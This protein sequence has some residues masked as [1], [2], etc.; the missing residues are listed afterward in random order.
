MN[1]NITKKTKQRLPLYLSYLKGIKEAG[2]KYASSP[3]IARAL[4][5]K[6]ILVRKDLAS[7]SSVSGRPKKGFEIDVLL[8]DIAG[9]MMPGDILEA[10]L[11]GAGNLGSALLKNEG[12][13]ECG[14]RIVAAFDNDPGRVGEEIGGRMVFDAKRLRIFCENLKIPIGIITV[15]AV[16][17]PLVCEELVNAGVGAIWN[18]SGVHLEVPGDV[19][20]R[21]ENLGAYLGMLAMEYRGK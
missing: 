7:V 9:I 15:P 17:A 2:A 14:V 3:D 16:H 12:L 20:L 19:V 21:E 10:V 13:E 5:L 1:Q 11:V 18:L 6:E 4:N 8:D